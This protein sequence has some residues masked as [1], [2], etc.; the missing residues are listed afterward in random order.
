LGVVPL[1]HI[2]PA[3]NELDVIGLVST[4][5]VDAIDAAIEVRGMTNFWKGY[6][7]PR[8]STS[9][10][11]FFIGIGNIVERN[12]IN[13]S[14]SFRT[15]SKLVEPTNSNTSVPPPMGIICFSVTAFFTCFT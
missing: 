11:L 5:V 10:T 14:T 2:Y 9:T 7:P 4:G 6:V 3:V 8:E 12:V 15:D 1:H 13:F